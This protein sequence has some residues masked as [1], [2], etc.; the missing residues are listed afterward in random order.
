MADRQWCN[1]HDHDV[2]ISDC[3]RCRLLCVDNPSAHESG[4]WS[5]ALVERWGPAEIERFL[6]SRRAVD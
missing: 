5:R 1:H 6:D 2:T 3:V 4:L